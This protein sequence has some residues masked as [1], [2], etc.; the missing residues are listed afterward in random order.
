[1]G[2]Y[3]SV[4][5]II[6]RKSDL[7]LLNCPEIVDDTT[8]PTVIG[9]GGKYILLYPLFPVHLSFHFQARAVHMV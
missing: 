4:S 6:T 2:A 3:P 1:M 9:G 7:H 5:L 8:A